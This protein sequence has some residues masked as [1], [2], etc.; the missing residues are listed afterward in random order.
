M[1]DQEELDESTHLLR[2]SAG[3]SESEAPPPPSG[4]CGI[5]HR[6]SNDTAESTRL[7]TQELAGDVIYGISAFWETLKPVA[8]TMILSS[9]ACNYVSFDQ[10]ADSS[11]LEI[12]SAGP[13]AGN[14][15]L[16]EAS[17]INAIIVVS[18]LAAL[19]FFIVFLYWMG[20]TTVL[21]VYLV[22]AMTVLLFILGGFL[23]LT[24]IQK[25]SLVFDYFTFFF[26]LYNF[27]AVGVLS[28]FFSKGIPKYIT[29]S[30]LICISVSV[31][32]FLPLSLF[33]KCEFFGI[34]FV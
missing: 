9:L 28:I 21:W 10:G 12:Y 23:F 25:F 1:A 11:G 30:Y 31:V 29:Q 34:C 19:T 5:N 20:W 8:L 16:I 27:A 15:E 3:R 13:K 26:I 4:D 14:A 32:H 7:S 6:A 18:I 33:F 2:D 17:I 24:I 22:F